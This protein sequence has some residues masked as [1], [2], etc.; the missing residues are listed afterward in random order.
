MDVMKNNYTKKFLLHCLSSFLIVT[1]LL[2][3]SEKVFASDKTIN[4]KQIRTAC[5]EALS[6]IQPMNEEKL[7]VNIGDIFN[8]VNTEGELDGY[9]LGYFVEEQPYGYAIYNIDDSSI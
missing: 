1:V 6:V 5:E 7:E 9:S 4:E 8:V 2:L 3:Y